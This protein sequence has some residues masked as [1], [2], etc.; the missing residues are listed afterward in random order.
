MAKNPSTRWYFNDWITEPGLR[1]CSAAARGL[2]M[3]MLC[4]AA[5]ATREGYV[6][7]DGKPCGVTE[8]ARISNSS[9]SNVRRWLAELEG[10]GVFSRTGEGTIYNRR[11]VRGVHGNG[12]KPPKST[13][14]EQDRKQP[15]LF[16]NPAQKPAKPNASLD[17][18]CCAASQD[19]PL[20]D[21]PETLNTA[22]PQEGKEGQV[23]VE[24]NPEE[25]RCARLGGADAP[26]CQGGADPPITETPVRTGLAG[27]PK[28]G[29]DALPSMASATDYRLS[30]GEAATGGR[31]AAPFLPPNQRDLDPEGQNHDNPRQEP[32]MGSSHAVS[33]GLAASRP[34]LGAVAMLGPGPCL[35][36]GKSPNNAPPRKSAALR[37][38]IRDQLI[39]KHARFLQARRPPQELAAYWAAMLDDDPAVAQSMLDAVDRRMRQAGWDDMRQWKLR[40]TGWVAIG[41]VVA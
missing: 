27:V 18:G 40:R 36:T 4:V 28:G 33:P 11:M 17:S 2:W 35:R 38:K 6:E 34:S 10:H 37:T 12:R 32:G 30:P 5:A 15:E 7:V 19:S 3:D 23:K 9:R 39:S 21:K 29:D 22:R 25:A 20:P 16:D 8:L 13:A 26:P 24:G 1:L 14:R 31:V 41:E